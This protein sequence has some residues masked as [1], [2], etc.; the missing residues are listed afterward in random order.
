MAKK[1][2]RVRNWIHYNE[3]LVQRGSVSIWFDK[4]LF[5]KWYESTISKGRGRPPFYSDVAIMCGLTLRSIYHLTLRATEGFVTSLIELLKLPLKMPDYTTLCKRQKTLKLE[6]TKSCRT[7]PVHIVV[8]STGLKVFGEGEWKVRQ[9]G[10]SKRRAWR[11]L[12][13]ALDESNQ[14]V[15]GLVLTTNDVADSEVVTDLLEQIS[16]L[17]NQFIGDGAYDKRSVYQALKQ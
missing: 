17:I 7:G 5:S 1:Q 15:M 9:H 4:A 2:Y 11:K 16:E 3:S 8:D 6:L 10:Y 12:H 13:I 14:E